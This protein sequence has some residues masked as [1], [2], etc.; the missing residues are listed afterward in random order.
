MSLSSEKHIMHR[1]RMTTTMFVAVLRLY[2]LCME[3]NLELT[4]VPST[5]K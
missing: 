3:A 5:S 4:K 2:V 1:L